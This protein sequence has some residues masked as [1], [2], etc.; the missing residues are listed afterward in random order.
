MDRRISAIR[1]ACCE[2]C[3][4]LRISAESSRRS[5]N[6]SMSSRCQI[7]LNRSPRIITVAPSASSGFGPE[8]SA[9][10][11]RRRVQFLLS[12]DQ[13]CYGHQLGDQLDS[14]RSAKTNSHNNNAFLPWHRGLIFGQS[15]AR[16]DSSS[17]II[18]GKSKYNPHYITW[19]AI[20]S[21]N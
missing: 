2:S 8:I 14:T 10:R 3:T 12:K 21:P 16:L 17:E 11:A 7:Y 18:D 13:R 9:K 15:K 19:T 5:Y 1:F 20:K 6:S 4:R